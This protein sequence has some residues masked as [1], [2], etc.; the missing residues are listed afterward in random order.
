M[1]PHTQSHDTYQHYD[2]NY[3][4]MYDADGITI[5]DW[6]SNACQRRGQGCCQHTIEGVSCET[7]RAGEVHEGNG[8]RTVAK[9]ERTQEYEGRHVWQRRYQRNEMPTTNIKI[10][11]KRDW[12]KKC[13]QK[14]KVVSCFLWK[15]RTKRH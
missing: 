15:L 8:E 10:I 7:G 12:M 13:L 14:Q 6:Y 3:H 9:A 1:F 2:N 4:D 11:K 5:H